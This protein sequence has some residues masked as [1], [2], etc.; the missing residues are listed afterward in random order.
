MVVAFHILVFV[1]VAVVV[2]MVVW[3]WR[4]IQA[5]QRWQ[6]PGEDFKEEGKPAMAEAM[7]LEEEARDVAV[8]GRIDASLEGE[9]T[10][11]H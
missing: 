1:I 3:E 11:G 10:S 7:P 6:R 8:S 5:R 4:Q 9:G 2:L